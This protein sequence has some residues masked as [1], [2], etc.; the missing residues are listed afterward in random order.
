MPNR[1]GAY[2][3]VAFSADGIVLRGWLRVPEGEGPHPLVILAHGLGGLKEWTIPDVADALI[4]AGIGA[5]AFDYRN[6]GDSGGQPREEVDH[7]GRIEDWRSAISYATT[8]PEIDDARIGIWG[9]S[10]G[11]RDVLAVAAIDRR[12]RCVTSQVP[13][14]KWDAS[15]GSWMAGFSGDLERYHR[16][17]AND[18][19]NRALG[20][21]PRYVPFEFPEDDDY[22]NNE[23]TEYRATWGEKER[24]N[25]KGRVTLQSYQPTI[26][27]DVMP[28]ME[29]IAPTPL[30]MLIAD[31]DIVPWQREAFEAALEPKSLVEFKGHHYSLYTTAK[32]EAIASARGW[33]AEYLTD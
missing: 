9:T 13:L 19:R 12:V 4:G 3:D 30:L 2:E 5:M 14:I 8:R 16:E 23:F 17:L 26:L 7:C 24:R 29:M 31:G 21:E 33:F 27:I 25:Y 6:F 22:G 10:L 32:Q 1:P 28:F 11:G 18:R 15:F 20:N